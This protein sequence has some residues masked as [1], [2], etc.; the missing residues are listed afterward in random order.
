M[1]HFTTLF[2]KNYLSRGLVLYDSLK[3]N[4]DS[5]VLYVL[6]LDGFTKKYFSEVT[7]VIRQYI[8]GRFSFYAMEQ[9]TDEILNH[10]SNDLIREEEK[11]KLKF[12]LRHADMVKFAKAQSLPTENENAIQFAYAFVNNTRPVIASDFDKTEESK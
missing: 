6:C 1:F 9:T 8:E 12:I 10:F 3:K 5:F 11:E 2:D 4:C 7:D